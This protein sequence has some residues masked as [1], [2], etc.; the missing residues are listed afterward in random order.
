MENHN[1]IFIKALCVTAFLGL[2]SCNYPSQ[3]KSTTAAPDTMKPDTNVGKVIAFHNGTNCFTHTQNNDSVFLSLVL[4]DSL[5][6][7][8]LQ[9]RL[10]EKDANTG[11]LKGVFHG[12]TLIAEYS[13][14]SEGVRSV[15]EVAFLRKGDILIEGTGNMKDNGHRMVFTN[16]REISFNTNLVL[17]TV[18]CATVDSK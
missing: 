16:R 18:D 2:M 13:F 5:V 15:R 17:E 9:Y 8:R 12:D 14:L 1:G 6:T 7:G 10:R 11:T 4:R 3:N